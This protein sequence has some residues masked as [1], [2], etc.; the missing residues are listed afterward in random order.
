MDEEVF[1]NE[2]FLQDRVQKIQQIIGKYGEENFYISFSGGKDSTV[3]SYLIDISIPGNTIPRVY[4]DTG[5]ELNMI[6]D[7]VYD[8]QKIDRRIE[9]I[10]P[11]M[12]IKQMLEKDGYPFKSKKHAKKVGTYQRNGMTNTTIEYLNPPENQKTFGCPE[13][14]KYNFTPE[15]RLKVDYKCCVNLKEKPL[16]SWGKENNRPYSIV[17][18]RNSE[19]G[20]RKKA[21]C[22]AFVGDKLRNF[23]PLVP[24]SDEWIEWF[25]EK[26]HIVLCEIYKPPYNFVRTGCKGCPFNMRLQKELDALARFFPNERKQCEIIWKPVYEE[27]RRISYRL[28]PDDQIEGQLSL[29]DI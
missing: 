21:K 11:K 27:Y 19:G 16:S 8:L 5:I 23:Q 2:F 24:V 28:R 18:I 22:L 25:V 10:K 26:Y 6:R 3:L 13:K 4:A 20:A 7:F 14:L 29:F 15:F 1:D 9:I 12:P 17:G